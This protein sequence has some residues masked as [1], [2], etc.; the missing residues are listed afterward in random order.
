MKHFST[1]I[2]VALAFT[3]LGSVG[4]VR[5]AETSPVEKAIE[6]VKDKLD[7]LVTAKDEKSSDELA[8][9][10]S[11]L[12]KVIE[13]SVTE[14]N[15]LKVKLIAMKTE[16]AVELWKEATLDKIEA[17]LAYY[18]EEKENLEDEEHILDLAGVKAAAESFKEWR[19]AHF[20]PVADMAQDFLLI[21]QEEKAIE[22]A[23]KRAA[24]IGEDVQKLKNA[25]Q[26][27]AKSL[28]P[29]LEK[30]N[31]LIE[32]AAEL[33][34]TAH[35]RFWEEFVVSFTTSTAENA[36]STEAAE[37]AT[38]SKA[39]SLSS[40]DAVSS[41]TEA[42]STVAAEPLPPSIRDLVKSSLTKVREAYQVFIE[43]STLVR[44]AL[45]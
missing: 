37:A 13:F 12:R 36:S 4:T 35:N 20:L 28:V 31:N 44:K 26:K 29:L 10:I 7:N 23:E 38:S 1:A 27:L 18:K 42:T 41:S 24:K 5:A 40:L 34:T 14:A 15:D 22:T 39:F 2:A 43:M 8:L 21:S 19:A 3:L 25:R 30:A 33:N 32:E 17:A 45:K 9:R 11:T 6:G 16:E